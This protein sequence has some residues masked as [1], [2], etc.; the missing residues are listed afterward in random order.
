[1]SFTELT[2]VFVLLPLTVISALALKWLKSEKLKNILILI[3]SLG[4]FIYYSPES[5]LVLILFILFVYLL[6]QLVYTAR[7]DARNKKKWMI[8]AVSSLVFVLAYSKYFPAILAWWNGF[9][10]WKI[11]Y[12]ELISIAGISFITF[13]GISYI[14]DIYRGNATPGSLP[15]AALYLSFFPKF[16]SGPIVLWKDFQEEMKHTRYSVEKLSSGLSRIIIGFA[17]KL[18]I[19]DTLGAHIAFIHSMAPNGIDRGTNW[20]IAIAYFFEI[21]YDFSGYSDIAIGLSDLFGFNLKENFNFPYISTSITEFWRRWH[22]SLGTW[23]RE[24]VYIPLGGN[25]TGNVYVN[26]FIVF[27]LT[28]IWHG[29]NYTFILW[30]LAHGIIII[31]ERAVKDKTWY[32]KI[33]SVIK[34]FFTMFFVFLAWILFMSPDIESAGSI[35]Q[36]LFTH[37][38]GSVDFTWRYFGSRK[39]LTVILIA[40][41]GALLGLLDKR[42][43]LKKKVSDFF[44]KPYI[45]W[46][47]YALLLALLILDILF[48]VNSSYSPFIYMQF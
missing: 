38:K 1:M 34:W 21:Y 23:F 31:L 17:K 42:E 27:L 25:R 40:G 26:L 16:V 4:I 37:T 18:L 35:Y 30:G 47:K 29:A 41:L 3:L 7:T 24:Y 20:L 6:G 28:G 39:I 44:S 33:P 2:F 19:A 22:I 8:V 46:I 9:K 10:I 43:S 5:L 11:T 48:L 45:V 32:K 13:S 12:T 36:A 14:V 15:D